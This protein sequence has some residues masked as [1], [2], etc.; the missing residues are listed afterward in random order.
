MKHDHPVSCDPDPDRGHARLDADR[1]GVSWTLSIACAG[2]WNPRAQPRREQYRSAAW[3][4][5]S[6]ATGF[7]RT[8][9]W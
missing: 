3:T 5:R 7:G 6:I 2:A 8:S 1:I 4:R 9:Q